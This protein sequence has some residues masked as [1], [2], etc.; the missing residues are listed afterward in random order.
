MKNIP[1]L[2]T[3]VAQPNAPFVALKDPEKRID[4]TIE[5]LKQWALISPGLEIVICDGSGYD[6][7]KLIGATPLLKALN[8][9]VLYFYN[10]LEMV[11]NKGKGY[12]EGEIIAYALNHSELLDKSD[13]FA[14]CTAKYWVNNF[15]ECVASH[16]KNISIEKY[17][18]SRY[19]LSYRAC[20]TRFYVV[21]KDFYLKKL[22]DS[23]KAS[24]DFQFYFLEHAFAKDIILNKIPRTDFKIKPLV[25]GISGSTG[26][27]TESRPESIRKKIVRK[28]RRNFSQ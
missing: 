4:S 11:K 1:V 20:D 14:K 3:S 27:F 10:D 13:T 7:Q 2:I 24:N 9:E 15:Q 16:R 18:D 25:Y 28:F 8:I 5:S 21:E 26:E 17:Y 6:F 19:S 22:L 23:H 12:G